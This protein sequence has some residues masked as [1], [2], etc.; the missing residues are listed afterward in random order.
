MTNT[1]VTPKQIHQKKKQK[2]NKN[3]K[4]RSRRP[5]KNLQARQITQTQKSIAGSSNDKHLVDVLMRNTIGKLKNKFV[6]VEKRHSKQGEGYLFR[7][8]A[9]S[10]PDERK[11]TI[12][13][14]VC[15]SYGNEQLCGLIVIVFAMK[16]QNTSPNNSGT[17]NG[18][19]KNDQQT[20]CVDSC[21]GVRILQYVD[22]KMIRSNTIKQFRTRTDNVA[23]SVEPIWK[24]ICENK[25]SQ[26]IKRRNSLDRTIVGDCKP[27]PNSY[28]DCVYTY[29]PDE[30]HTVTQPQ[31]NI[32][33]PTCSSSD[34]SV[35]TNDT[36]A[37]GCFVFGDNNSPVHDKP[38]TNVTPQPS[39]SD[40]R[41][42]QQ[43]LHDLPVTCD[44]TAT[45]LDRQTSQLQ[46]DQQALHTSIYGIVRLINSIKNF[47]F[48]L[49]L[50]MFCLL[51]FFAIVLV[52]CLIF[53][54]RNSRTM[55]RDLYI[56][57]KGRYAPIITRNPETY[58]IF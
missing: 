5:D 54:C 53:S 13:D 34:N 15:V 52:H 44:V 32:Q 27:N 14:V 20:G 24:K 33:F 3:Q 10:F 36:D 12:N 37:V 46:L 6:F 26:K 7:I 38:R 48:G 57:V 55:R 11:T 1:G 23:T 45:M 43:M 18:N 42:S 25:I 28:S 22:N 58:D 50:C 40:L 8:D 41:V 30:P 56:P 29:S 9:D 2:G 21:S 51:R 4:G 19:S 49:V 31:S 39:L 35:I 16:D 47:V 17:P